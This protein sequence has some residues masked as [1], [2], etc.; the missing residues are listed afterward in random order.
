MSVIFIFC[1]LL[2]GFEI[3]AYFNRNLVDLAFD[4][5]VTLLGVV[6]IFSVECLEVI[7]GP[8]W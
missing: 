1:S 3:F 7:L 8:S 4:F 6:W 5:C 2:Y